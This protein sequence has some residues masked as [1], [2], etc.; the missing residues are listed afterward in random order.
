MLGTG[1]MQGRPIQGIS[2]T[3]F[4]Y[5]YQSTRGVVGEHGSYFLPIVA[6]NQTV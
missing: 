3:Q 1:V 6:L 2:P 4:R 5:K